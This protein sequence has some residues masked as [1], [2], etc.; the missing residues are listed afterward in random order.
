MK[1]NTL[2]NKIK[3]L[4]IPG[5]V[6]ASRRQRINISTVGTFASA[7]AVSFTCIRNR[8]LYAFILALV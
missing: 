4:L 8:F 6:A 2:E 1:S 3:I 7:R 5:S